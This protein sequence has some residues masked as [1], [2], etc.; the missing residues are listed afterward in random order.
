MNIKRVI[1]IVMIVLLISFSFSV[2][3][4][5]LIRKELIQNKELIT[6]VVKG[7]I[8]SK[9]NPENNV[10]NEE[11]LFSFGENKVVVT[12]N[13]VDINYDKFNDELL[14]QNKLHLD[15]SNYPNLF[16]PENEF[17]RLHAKEIS[18][19]D[20]LDTKLIYIARQ[21]PNHGGIEDGYYVIIDPEVGK[22]VDTGYN[23]LF[24]NIHF[25][26]SCTN[27]ALPVLLFREYDREHQKFI[28]TNNQHKNE[29]AELLKQYENRGNKEYCLLNGENI[30]VNELIKTNKDNEKCGD[31]NDPDDKPAES[32]IT[33]G[34]YKQI[35]NNIKEIINGKN[36]EMV[37]QGYFGEGLAPLKFVTYYGY[38]NKISTSGEASFYWYDTKLKK[39]KDAD[40]QYAWFWAM[41]TSISSDSAITD[42][43]VMFI[44]N[45]Q[46]S[47]FKISGTRD[48]DDCNYWDLNHCIENI[49]IKT[50][51]VV[52]K[53][54]GMNF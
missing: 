17:A 11:T 24:G 25:N 2:F 4:K 31:I 8:L 13:S 38:I 16:E 35:I 1:T 23:Q 15:S 40:N 29:F 53:N 28:L 42:K 22:V 47:A 27:C 3:K 18:G 44:K 7:K 5:K 39:I 32:F 34:E 48:K 51:E 20:K 46:D 30:L 12:S 37:N 54:K 36:I 45:N 50:I 6:S 52:D 33:V 9:L 41:P 21:V 26:N 19:G 14:N 10:K 49:D 43:W